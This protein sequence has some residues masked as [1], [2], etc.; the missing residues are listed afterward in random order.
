M[1]RLDPRHY[2]DAVDVSIP[3]MNN[4]LVEKPKLSQYLFDLFDSVNF[5]DSRKGFY[6]NPKTI[7]GRAQDTEKSLR[8]DFQAFLQKV[9]D[10]VAY[11]G[12]PPGTIGKPPVPNPALDQFYNTIEAALYHIVMAIRQI[13]DKDPEKAAEITTSF[14]VDTLKGSGQCGGRIHTDQMKHYHVIV[15]G[16]GR[17]FRQQL[18]DVLARMRQNI[19]ESLMPLGQVGENSV[20][21]YNACVANFGDELKIFGAKALKEIPDQL[22]VKDQQVIQRIKQNF[23]KNYN[24]AQIIDW[25]CTEIKQVEEFRSVFIDWLKENVPAN[26]MKKRY[27]D[28]TGEFRKVFSEGELNEPH[29]ENMEQ[30]IASDERIIEFFASYEIHVDIK[31]KIITPVEVIAEDRVQEY[32]SHILDPSHAFHCTARIV[33]SLVQEQVLRRR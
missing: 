20:H 32:L 25:V 21:L 4:V 33:D 30:P 31:N 27:E 3:E 11:I 28:I 26:F 8:K 18:A 19:L 12:T 15:L 10:H 13:R 17:K 6:T 22:A 1:Y 2:N 29:L 9:K 7:F 24:A 14:I 23:L 5:S 16:R